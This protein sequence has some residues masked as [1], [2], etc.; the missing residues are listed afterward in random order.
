MI[1]AGPLMATIVFF[2]TPLLLSV[3][4]DPS[5]T[6]MLGMGY[7]FGTVPSIVTAVAWSLFDAWAS[8]R[9]WPELAAAIIGAVVSFAFEALA[10]M[11]LF[12]GPAFDIVIDLVLAKLALGGAIA[13]GVSVGL[14][15]ALDWRRRLARDSARLLNPPWRI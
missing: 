12:E 13:A 7:A 6:S 3:P 2:Y 5:V 9:L 11:V 15:R 8:L 4:P 1:L 14:A 10:F